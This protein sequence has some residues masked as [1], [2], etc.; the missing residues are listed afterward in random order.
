MVSAYRPPSIHTLFN[1]AALAVWCSVCH[2]GCHVLVWH[3]I[4]GLLS[5]ARS[6]IFATTASGPV[7]E[8]LGTG[9]GVLVGYV[10]SVF[11][12]LSGIT[13]MLCVQS[14]ILGDAAVA[15]Q[16]ERETQA[17]AQSSVSGVGTP[18]ISQSFR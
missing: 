18:T 10:V 9:W 3:F 11:V 2:C 4:F 14:S 15:V 6:V 8:F 16:P 5:A 13:L 7:I 1:G 17:E 12:I